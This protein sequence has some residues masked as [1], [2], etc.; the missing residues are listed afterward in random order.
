MNVIAR[1]EYELAYYDSTVHRFNHYTTRTPPPFFYPPLGL[2]TSLRE[3]KNSKFKLVAL[4]LK[5]WPCVTSCL[6]QR[7]WVNKYI[8]ASYSMFFCMKD[9]LQTSNFHTTLLGLVSNSNEFKISKICPW[10][11][12]N[13]IFYQENF[14]IIYSSK[15]FCSISVTLNIILS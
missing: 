5:N 11:W 10:I 7:E 8:Q 15:Y 6:W 12:M 2:V 13:K 14:I 3:K 4:C 1:L 9:I